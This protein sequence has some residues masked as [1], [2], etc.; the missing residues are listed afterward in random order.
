MQTL[1][2]KNLEGIIHKAMARHA[3]L[4]FEQWGSHANPE[5]RAAAFGVGARMAGMGAALVGHMAQ[6]AYAVRVDRRSQ[7]GTWGVGR[8]RALTPATACAD[9]LHERP[10]RGREGGSRSRPSWS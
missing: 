8:Q 3:R 2:D 9:P 6:A 1:R 4:P 10:E 7:G 5:V